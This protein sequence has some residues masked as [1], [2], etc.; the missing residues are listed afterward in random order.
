MYSLESAT[1]GAGII[2]ICQNIW[3]AV[4]AES[5]ECLILLRIEIQMKVHVIFHIFEFY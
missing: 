2:S 3:K 5:S 1:D 4:T